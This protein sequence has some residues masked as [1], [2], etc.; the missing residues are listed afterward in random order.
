M[1]T[2]KLENSARDELV[3]ECLSVLCVCVGLVAPAWLGQFVDNLFNIKQTT[4]RT[5]S[6]RARKHTADRAST[7][8]HT[9]FPVWPRWFVK[10]N[11]RAWRLCCQN[12]R[13]NC[14]P[15]LEIIYSIHIHINRVRT[16]QTIPNHMNSHCH[17]GGGDRE[18][19]HA[20]TLCQRNFLGN[21][22]V[23][24]GAITSTERILQSKS[25][26]NMESR[27]VR[28]NNNPS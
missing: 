3:Y 6:I 18:N 14:E 17:P 13:V 10:K 21:F 16:A 4:K 22:S 26:Q 27:A 12:D 2:G 23:F 24:L 15:S 28:N 9:H 11:I 7:K 1:I 20:T 8:T 25:Y 19:P 5:K